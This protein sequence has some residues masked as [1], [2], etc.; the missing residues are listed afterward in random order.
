M[1]GR[2]VHDDTRLV[3]QRVRVQV[4][5]QHALEHVQQVPDRGVVCLEARPKHAPE[6]MERW[7]APTVTGNVIADKDGMLI[8]WDAD[9]RVM[10][11]V[12]ASTGVVE[13]TAAIPEALNV[14]AD[15]DLIYILGHSTRL[16]LLRLGSGD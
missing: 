14:T 2:E 9:K 8:T 5:P 11:S 10:Q 12:S 1:T 3:D 13:A 15:G 6:G 4:K 16:Q 7:T